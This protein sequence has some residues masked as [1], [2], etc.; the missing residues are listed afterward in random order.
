MTK[1]IKY[2]FI[3]TMTL[4]IGSCKKLD[5]L[6]DNP[7]NPTP[8]QADV[9]LYLNRV[10][11]S[12]ASLYN[13]ASD[14]GGQ[15]TRMTVFY[16]PTYTEGYSPQSFDG[17]WETAYTG[18]IKNADAMIPLAKQQQKNFHAGIA[19]V[20]KAYTLMTLVDLFGEVPYTEAAKGNDNINPKVEAGKNIYTA[21]LALLDT[22]IA[23]LT[24]ASASNP[25]SILFSP[26]TKAGWIKV[27]NTIKLKAYITTRLV[28][29]TAGAKIQALLTSGN[30]I[31][32]DADEFTFKYGTQ[33][34]TPNARHPR[35][36]EGYYPPQ[37][38]ASDYI[39][40]YF[41][42]AVVFEKGVSDPRARY[43][44]YRQTLATPGTQQQQFCAYQSTPPHFSASD[45]FCLLPGGYWGR[46]HGDN[47]GIPPDGSL[48]TV[49]GVY[50][51]GGKF[52]CSDGKGTT[53]EEGG[54]GAGIH[55]I[56]MSFF[57]DFVT[58]E[59][60]LTTTGVTADARAALES[61]VTK[62]ITRV[63]NFPSQRAAPSGP[64]D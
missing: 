63:M 54:R 59:A 26:T 61:G 7:N 19:E 6:L 57:T 44:F 2:L 37:G 55:P 48:R 17:I 49:W 45:V 22:A 20:L 38:G 33:Y 32:T 56:W 35:Y 8:E 40:T 58:A 29:A 3:V 47:S 10:Q 64:R 43:Y 51:A 14:F 60:A 13:T 23:D 1:L 24:K 50:P 27:A 15:L 11:L 42:N 36:N 4:M 28:D 34:S 62:S 18:V 46:D 9:D 12:F 53:L 5:K 25:T 52:D 30:I 21:A 41:L 31:K 39:G 16:G